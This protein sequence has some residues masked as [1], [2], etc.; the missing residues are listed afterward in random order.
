MGGGLPR[1]LF[2]SISHPIAHTLIFLS[3]SYVRKNWRRSEGARTEEWML[4]MT[5]TPKQ[6]PLSRSTL[7]PQVDKLVTSFFFQPGW[8][9]VM[10]CQRFSLSPTL[11]PCHKPSLTTGSGAVNEEVLSEGYLR[12]RAG[13]KALNCV[14]KHTA[15]LTTQL[16]DTMMFQGPRRSQFGKKPL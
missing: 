12:G 10:T 4:T 5:E 3:C 9:S 8:R 13:T 15:A 16:K 1:A 14:C 2:L 11:F 6:P 7:P